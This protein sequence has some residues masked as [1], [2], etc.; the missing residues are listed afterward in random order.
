MVAGKEP[1]DSDGR[2][3]KAL[4]TAGTATALFLGIYSLFVASANAGRVRPLAEDGLLRT[5]VAK[6]HE[7]ITRA[8]G[9]MSGSEVVYV[10]IDAPTDPPDPGIEQATRQAAQT[11]VDSGLA[12]SARR[13][14]PSDP[15]FAAVVKQNDV[16]RFPAVLVVKKDGG[17][18][19]VTENHSVDNLV[20]A[21]HTVWGRSSDCGAARDEIS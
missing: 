17:I 16:R 3:K 10:A 9:S 7:R 20:R 4:L 5:A 12:A 18:V 8:L 6:D 19:L 14:R 13:L 2:V 1:L 11:L 15:D 21:F